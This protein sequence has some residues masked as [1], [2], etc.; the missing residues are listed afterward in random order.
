MATAFKNRLSANTDEV[1][2]FITSLADEKE[3]FELDI[4]E[5][6]K[7]AKTG[8]A[9]STKK[10]DDDSLSKGLIALKARQVFETDTKR[11]YPVEG[12]KECIDYLK[13]VIAAGEIELS[14]D[15]EPALKKWAEASKIAK[16]EQKLAKAK[17][18]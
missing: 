1:V 8:R 13:K 7:L 3:D 17:S 4:R 11:T 10:E 16:L 15:D 6:M 5:L 12:K 9:S 14:K 18:K 2:K